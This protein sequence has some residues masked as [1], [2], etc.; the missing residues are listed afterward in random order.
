MIGVGS[1]GFA[2]GDPWRLLYATNYRGEVCGVG[3]NSDK[4]LIFYPELD[5]D[6]VRFAE[7]SAVGG[8]TVSLKSFESAGQ[9]VSKCPH[10]GQIFTMA[11]ISYPVYFNQSEVMMRCFSKYPMSPLYFAKCKAFEPNATTTAAQLQQQTPKKNVVQPQAQLI[12][13]TCE[14]Y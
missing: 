4:P 11:N 9:C 2:R 6:L 7:R 5:Q 12:E 3:N 8:G 13:G 1:F 10:M 14:R